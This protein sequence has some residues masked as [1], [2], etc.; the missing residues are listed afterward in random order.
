MNNY[1]TKYPRT[2]HLP[3]SL[4]YTED[5]NVLTDASH[6]KRER[7]VV[8]IKMDGENT[9]MYSDHIHARSLDSV[10][11]ESRNWVKAFHAERCH[12]IPKGWRIC[13]EN[14]YA[15]HSIHYTN[16]LSYFYGFSVWNGPLCKS[17]DETLEWFQL[18]NIVPVPLLYRGMFDKR[19]IDSL[20]YEYCVANDETE[21]YV[22]RTERSFLSEDFPYFVAKYVRKNHVNTSTHWMHEKIVPNELAI[23]K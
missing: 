1:Y 3:W 23:L 13:G 5:D 10:G 17:W 2:Y 19:T 21:G 22:I 11:H 6:F 15:T 14:M 18:L 8:T 16:L 12:D 20:F 9:S 4:G 7:V